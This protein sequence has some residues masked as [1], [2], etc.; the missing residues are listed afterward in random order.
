M[1]GTS[2]I[3]ALANRRTNRSA[4]HERRWEKGQYVAT[5]TRS[6]VNTQV[7]LMV[8]VCSN[9]SHISTVPQCIAHMLPWAGLEPRLHSKI[10]LPNY[11]SYILCILNLLK[12]CVDILLPSFTK[13]LHLSLA[14]S[15]FPQN[16]RRRLLPH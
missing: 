6:P 13:L 10:P 1:G 15:T 16:S 2:L 5:T 12:D 3:M 14:K 7:W 9:S 11:V 8:L 4:C